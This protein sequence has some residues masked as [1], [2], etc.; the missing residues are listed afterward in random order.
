VFKV[1]KVW[2]YIPT[3]M[4]KCSL[5]RF[6]NFDFIKDKVENVCSSSTDPMTCTIIIFVDLKNYRNECFKIQ[7]AFNV[8]QSCMKWL[9][10]NGISIPTA[11]LNFMVILNMLNYI[12]KALTNRM[13][14]QF[15]DTSR[16]VFVSK[17]LTGSKHR[18]LP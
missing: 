3:I 2:E 18:S 4:C 15:F 12:S 14:K 9:T 17:I 8:C 11:T 6:F 1:K 13:A 10:W 16:D 7:K 5:R